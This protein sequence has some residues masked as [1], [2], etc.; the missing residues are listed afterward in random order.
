MARQESLLETEFE[1]G[2]VIAERKLTLRRGT[3]DLDV[4]VTLGKPNP[5][6][7]P[8][9]FYCFYSIEIGEKKKISHGCGVD[10]FQAL[11]LA[12]Q[13]IGIDLSIIQRNE[14]GEFVWADGD[15]GQTGFPFPPLV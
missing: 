3:G 12:M 11:Q 2:E 10:G 1:I 7:D 8:G 14:A 9:E 5:S 4:C 6:R 15:P 13:R